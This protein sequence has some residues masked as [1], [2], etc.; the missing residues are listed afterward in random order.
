MGSPSTATVVPG[1]AP[2][3]ADERW[4]CMQLSMWIKDHASN[5]PWSHDVRVNVQYGR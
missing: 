4:E 3:Q 5:H 1:S 2:D